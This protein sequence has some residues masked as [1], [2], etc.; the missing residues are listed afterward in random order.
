MR[1]TVAQLAPH[2]YY[3]QTDA[4]LVVR[5][6]DADELRSGKL[7][8]VAAWR[9]S[10]ESKPVEFAG[11]LFDFDAES[12]S[13]VSTIALAGMGSPTGNWTTADNV[14]VP[15]DAGFMQGLFAAMIQR[16]GNTHKAQRRMKT[17]LAALTDAAAIAA[18]EV[19]Q[20]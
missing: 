2:Q 12:R 9:E 6:Y 3:E 5:E 19:P 15:A 1:H 10:M 4:G 11:H 8:A 16:T 14:D 13:R 17:E 20:C 7:A 18:Y